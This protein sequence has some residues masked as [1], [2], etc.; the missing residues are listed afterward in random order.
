MP[1][2]IN[3]PHIAE[4]LSI[5]D[6]KVAVT[7]YDEEWEIVGEQTVEKGQC[8]VFL[9]GGHALRMLEPTRIL[10]VKQGPYLGND[11]ILHNA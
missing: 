4:F 2:S 1:R 3:L 10:E 8:I 11:K 6:G 7:I 9:R 5:E